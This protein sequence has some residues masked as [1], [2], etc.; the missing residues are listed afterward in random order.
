MTQPTKQ[1]LLSRWALMQKQMNE[2]EYLIDQMPDDEPKVVQWQPQRGDYFVAVHGGIVA[3]KPTQQAREFGSVRPTEEL[4]EKAR[5]AMRIHNRLLAY[6]HEFAPDYEP[7]WKSTVMKAY[8]TYDHELKEWY[9]YHDMFCES[10]GTVYM[11][12]EVAES[13]VEKLN[14]GE[15]VL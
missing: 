9:L 1:E 6:T 11:P 2:L 10:P 14:R 3:D 4:A 7:D 13:L 5:D 12:E 15:V 8:V